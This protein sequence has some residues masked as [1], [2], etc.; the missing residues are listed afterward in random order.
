MFEL[1]L[2]GEFYIFLISISHGLVI[3]LIYDLHRALRY[4]SK[5]KK[6]RAYIED[7]LLW[8]I[9]TAL[10]FIFLLENTAGIVRGFVIIG[11]IVGFTFYLKIISKYS[12]PLIIKIFKL[13]LRLFNEIMKLII[14]PFRGVNVFVKKRTRRFYLLLKGVFK[15]MKKYRRIIS[16]KK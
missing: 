16:R 10:F 4:F 14:Y 5:P 1:D 12:L 15:D 13:I 9:I 2:I 7:L 6:V 8:I 11:F 3:G